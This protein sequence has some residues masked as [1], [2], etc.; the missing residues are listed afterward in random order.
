M[1]LHA[2]G[3]FADSGSLISASGGNGGPPV[4]IPGQLSGFGGGG[5]GGSGG[6]VL[7]EF[8]SGGMSIP[9][10]DVNLSGGT[11]SVSSPT[12]QGD[13]GVFAFGSFGGPI[14]AVQVPPLTVVP[15]PPSL[16]LLVVSMSW[17]SVGLAW[18]R[19]RA[20]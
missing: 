10:A 4:S 1:F 19:R 8:G 7:V 11:S 3:V 16:L 15:E 20:A 9:F 13:G 6:R 17:L 5:G 18:R 2:N 12:S 14:T